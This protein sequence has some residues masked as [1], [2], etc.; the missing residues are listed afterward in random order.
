MF[1]KP[2]LMWVDVIYAVLCQGRFDLRQ[3]DMNYV[4]RNMI[5]KFVSSSDEYFVSEG[6]EMLISGN[7]SLRSEFS[8]EEPVNLRKL[9]YGAKSVA[10]QLNQPTMFEHCIPAAVVRDQLV[11]ARSAFVENQKSAEEFKLAVEAILSNAGSVV[12]VLKEEN[13]R[14]SRSTMPSD[15]DYFSSDKLARY[16]VASPEVKISSLYKAQRD[17]HICR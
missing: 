15:W 11:K 17:Q 14:L 12:I 8:K 16:R 6:V 3:G 4:I 13:L 2:Q 9:F 10:A 7:Q 5:A 1:N